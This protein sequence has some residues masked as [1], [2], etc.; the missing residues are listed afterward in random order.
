M[1]EPKLHPAV[2]VT[3]IKAYIPVTLDNEASDYNLWSELFRIHCTAFLVS[4]H[5]APRPPPPAVS[6]SAD[7]ATTPTPAPDSWER[8]DAIVL[9]WIYG[10]ITPS[11]L[12]TVIIKRTTA[13]DAWK[14]LESLFQ[15]NKATRA[16][17]LKQ[18]FSNVRLENFSSMT[19]YCQELKVLSDQLA[20][21]DAPV[22]EQDLVLQTLAGLTD[23]YETVGTILQNTKPLPNFFEVRSQLC[24]SET[25]KASQATHSANA[26]A[27]AL[28]VQAQHTSTASQPPSNSSDSSRFRDQNRSRG[29]G[30]RRP[31]NPSQSRNRYPPLSGQPSHPYIIFPQSWA[32]NQWPNLL[33]Q[34][35]NTSS[36]NHSAQY[37]PCPY[38]AS[39]RPNNGQGILGP[40]PAQAHLATYSPTPT[41]IAQALYTLSLNQSTE[42]VGYMDTGAS[43]HIEQ[44]GSQDQGTY[45]S[46]Q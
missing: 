32:Q 9:Q 38:P 25:T 31:T 30:R 46:M 36:S 39:P 29:Q 2:T 40:S 7:K 41:D 45:P 42:P 23:Q 21:V 1:A 22:D 44:P 19:A 28:H 8:L 27:T 20:G 15:D 43:G 6:T 26:A 35:R 17:Y 13:Y 14:A 18:K 11:L 24:M 34:A 5:L 12:K 10:T 37:P 3:N 33:Q 4:D 16:L